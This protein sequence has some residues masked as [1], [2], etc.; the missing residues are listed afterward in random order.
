MNE[1][2]KVLCEMGNMSLGKSTFPNFEKMFESNL[3]ILL[4]DDGDGERET[5]DCALLNYS[6]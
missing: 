4:G 6:K 5:S 2:H 3:P 1:K